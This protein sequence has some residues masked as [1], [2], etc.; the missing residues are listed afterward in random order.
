MATTTARV[1]ISSPDLMPGSALS[2]NPPGV[3]LTKAGVTTGLTQMETGVRSIVTGTEYRL[4]PLA[5]EMLSDA[6]DIA[7]YLYLCNT[8][9][10]DTTYYID[11]GIHETM[12]GKL[13]AGD[14]MFI[15]WNASDDTAEI[16]IE[17]QGGTNT[18]E[19]AFFN[20]DFI[21]TTAA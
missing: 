20:S 8:T 13:Y 3:Q 1:S 4:G 18:I 11:W 9:T 2:I 17:P 7:S 5:T 10:E 6:H 16:E 12:I 15:P 14:W 21:L 19:Y